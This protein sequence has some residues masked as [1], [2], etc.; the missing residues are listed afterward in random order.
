MN[1]HYGIYGIKNDLFEYPIET[2]DSKSGVKEKKGVKFGN[3]MN[4]NRKRQICL[5]KI[6]STKQPLLYGAPLLSYLKIK[7]E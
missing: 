3:G 2:V 5:D 7:Q 6:N 1:I 4:K